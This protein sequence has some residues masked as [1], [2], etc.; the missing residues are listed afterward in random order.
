MNMEGKVK[1]FKNFQIVSR[2][3]PVHSTFCRS[4]RRARKSP[5]V[6]VVK[7]YVD[8]WLMSNDYPTI[9]FI[10]K[11]KIRIL[12]TNFDVVR[13][14]NMGSE[15]TN[16]IQ[17]PKNANTRKKKWKK[18]KS[19]KKNRKR[20]I[21]KMVKIFRVILSSVEKIEWDRRLGCG[22]KCRACILCIS[23]SS[24]LSLFSALHA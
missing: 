5:S 6:K 15:S 20:Y 9:I 18:R 2:V 16:P 19:K 13:S 1:F 23:L 12:F 8:C 7:V 11:K 21:T 17:W 10:F 3:L 22:F 24:T 14:T 4:D